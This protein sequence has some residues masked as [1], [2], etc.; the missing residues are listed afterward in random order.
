[1]LIINNTGLCSGAGNL[2]L[3]HVSLLEKESLNLSVYR[4]IGPFQQP[5]PAVESRLQQKKAARLQLDASLPYPGQFRVSY[6]L[7][8]K[9]L[10]L[11]VKCW[12]SRT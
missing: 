8:S 4:A 7:M 11:L 6:I 10:S 2:L 9:L 5:E 12:C 3:R 1:M